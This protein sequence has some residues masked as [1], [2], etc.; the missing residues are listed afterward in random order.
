[1]NRVGHDR[2]RFYHE[3]SADGIRH[4]SFTAVHLP[5]FAEPRIASSTY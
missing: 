5:S 1:V 3:A 4:T 2:S